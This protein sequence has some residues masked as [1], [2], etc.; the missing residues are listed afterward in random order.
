MID[1]NKA[2]YL[3]KKLN[4]LLFFFLFISV[5][6]IAQI[7][8]HS[9]NIEAK[10]WSRDVNRKIQYSDWKLFPSIVIDSI[11]GYR[12]VREIKT[13]K[14]GAN[15]TEKSKATGYFR[16]EKI[17]NRW[18]VIDPLGHPFVVKAVNGVRLGKSPNNQKAFEDKFTTNEKW[19]QSVSD[20]FHLSGFNVAGSWSDI[21]TIVAYNAK[22][23]SPLVY[24]TQLSLLG[25]FKSF[26]GKKEPGRK[27][28]SELSLIFDPEFIEYCDNETKKIIPYI[29]DPNLL[30]H[31]SD[32]ELPFTSSE[33]NNLIKEDN[34]NTTG[35]RKAI[36]WMME[37]GVNSST[38]TSQQK[39][40]FIGW[41]T[42]QYY[43]IV[44]GAIK[45]HDPNHLYIGSRLH[46]SAKNNP[47]IF[48]AAE[49]YIDIISINYYGFWQ[50][51]ET[52]LIDWA[53]WS[54]KPFFITEFYTKA[55]ETG[56]GN[57][58]GA[59]WLVKTQNDRGIHY[60]NFC[61]TLLKAKNCVGWH[62]FRYQDNDPNDP[63]ADPSNKD[64]NKGMVDTYYN[65]YDK[66]I[67]K[68][69]QLND[70]VYS[71]IHFFDN[72]NE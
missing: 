62:W 39:E 28:E 6:A 32:N 10:E 69:K 23:N 20:T 22:A 1:A 17:N 46:A 15:I 48:K 49:P 14:F 70:N 40:E 43:S 35:Y 72:G 29:N 33:F 68:M 2:I 8:S 18:W 60:Q 42:S 9:V 25:G 30:G 63:Y 34:N 54:D 59:G 71:L 67:G 52:H 53:T 47:Y 56:M 66:L 55:E 37:K 27:D 45:K 24:T 7:N 5:T 61:L 41:I 44:S 51:K 4:S 11:D 50:P 12:P 16:T 57:I 31:F 13:D 58:S 38:I 26:I 3:F 21:E 19:I 65:F 36:K 64:S